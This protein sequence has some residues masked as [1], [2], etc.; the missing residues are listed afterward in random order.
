MVRAGKGRALVWAAVAWVEVEA[1][2]AVEEL[3]AA[4]VEVGAEA[5]ADPAL[6]VAAARTCGNP[7]EAVV[8]RAAGDWELEA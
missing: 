1:A 2:A 4:E 8:V 5:P 6:V 3:V 7:A